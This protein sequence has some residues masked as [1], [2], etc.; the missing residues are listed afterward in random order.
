[1]YRL[2]RIVHVKYSVGPYL[3]VMVTNSVQ[4]STV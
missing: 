3:L 2:G 1:M 4:T